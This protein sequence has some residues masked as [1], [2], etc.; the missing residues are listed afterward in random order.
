MISFL[1]ETPQY[2]DTLANK[3]STLLVI[4]IIDLI[5]MRSLGMFGKVFSANCSWAIT[6]LKGLVGEA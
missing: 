5:A 4:N 3:A 6:K 1:S 2:K